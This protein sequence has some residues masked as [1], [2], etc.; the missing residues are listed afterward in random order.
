MRLTFESS[1][2]YTLTLISSDGQST[3]IDVRVSAG[4]SGPTNLQ[5]AQAGTSGTAIYLA[6]SY[7]SD[8][9]DGFKVYRKAASDTQWPSSPLTSIPAGTAPYGFQDAVPTPYGTYSYRITAYQGTQ[10]S[11]ASNAE[12]CFQ[13]QVGTSLNNTAMNATFNPG[14]S[15]NKIESDFGFNHVNWISWLRYVPP[16]LI[17][18]VDGQ[19]NPIGTPPPPV[20]DPPMGGWTA[21]SRP[22]VSD[23]LPY[24][25]DEVTGLDP[26]YW[27]FSQAITTS[28]STMFYDIPWIPYG[29][30]EFLTQLVGVTLAPGSP[31]PTQYDVLASFVWS[32]N[33]NGKSGAAGTDFEVSNV[34]PPPMS[35]PGGIFN[36]ELVS[37][38]DLPADIRGADLRTGAQNVSQTKGADKTAPMTAAFLSGPAGLGGWYKGPV[39]V[40]LITTDIDGPTDIAGTWYSVDGGSQQVYAGPIG[41]FNDGTHTVQFAGWDLA[42]NIEPTKSLAF[43]IDQ[44]PPSI[45]ASRSPAPNGNDWNKSSVTVTFQCSDAV[46]GLAAGSPPAPTTVTTEGKG[47]SVVGTCAN[48]AGISASLAVSDINIDLTPPVVSPVVTPAPNSNGWNN[49]AVTVAFHA[50]DALSGVATVTPPIVVSGDGAGQIVLGMATDRAGNSSKTQAIV[51][52]DLE[53]PDAYF[54]FDPATGDLVF[55]GRDRLSGVPAGAIPP[56]SEV[57]VRRGGRED[58]DHDADHDDREDRDD[59]V[60]RLR[61]TYKAVNLAGN[62]ITIIADVKKHE[63]ELAVSIVSIQYDDRPVVTLGPNSERFE[64]AIHR[65]QLAE[66]EQQFKLGATEEAPRI[67]A[68]FDLR[69]NQTSIRQTEPEP[70]KRL[71]KSGLVLLRLATSSGQLVIEY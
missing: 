67:E 41:V 21:V 27:L 14:A 63:H 8:T 16:G 62:S 52:I 22:R 43:K 65:D 25:W 34:V 46:S 37:Q 38:A 58:I 20:F 33:Y 23:L 12:T 44:T 56:V 57:V 61:R 17:L 40:T 3:D 10:E 28:S 29:H 7:G 42:G 69:R 11:H 32:T 13:I 45:S 35:G 39:D 9:I 24:Y 50:S 36:V 48:N 31:L 6:W 60:T 47:Q 68:H 2:D 19:G 1:G 51:N 18:G 53:P 26:N 30:F 70:P 54:Q 59:G 4:L 49:T 5:V 15:L 66:L 64:W 55:F 71:V